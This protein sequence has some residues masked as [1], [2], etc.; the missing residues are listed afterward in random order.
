MRGRERESEWN[1]EKG[2]ARKGRERR[3]NGWSSMG[4]RGRGEEIGE[5]KGQA[6]AGG[7]DA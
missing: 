3:T 5:E 2:R 6:Q 1:G 7:R 4:K